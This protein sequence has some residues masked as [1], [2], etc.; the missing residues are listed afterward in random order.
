M[1]VSWVRLLLL[2]V[3][4]P[5]LDLVISRLFSSYFSWPWILLWVLGTAALGVYT[6]QKRAV[7]HHWDEN[8]HTGQMSLNFWPLISG[9][10]LIL[11]GILGDALGLLLMSKFRRPLLRWCMNYLTGRKPFATSRFNAGRFS[12]RESRPR[13]I[14]VEVIPPRSSK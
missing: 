12:D 2:V 3:L 9:V 10:L 4:L 8:T 13:V 11:P 6:I 7:F 1:A 14:D 5:F